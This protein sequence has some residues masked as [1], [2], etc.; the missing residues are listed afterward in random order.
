[1]TAPDSHARPPGVTDETVEALGKLS[2]A[3]EWLER[4]RGRLYDLHQMVGHLDFQMDEAARLFRAAGHDD[5]AAWVEEE[6]IGR[7]VLD[8]R[9]TFQIVEEFDDLYYEPIRAGERRL[10]DELADGRRHLFEAE[11][12]EQRRTHGRSGHER[13]PPAMHEPA[14]GAGSEDENAAAVM[15][16]GEPDPATIPSGGCLLSTARRG[17]VGPADAIR[18]GT[19]PGTDD[20]D[21]SDAERA[22]AS[23]VGDELQKQV[24]AGEQDPE[25]AEEK[26]IA[27]AERKGWDQEQTAREGSGS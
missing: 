12:K 16:P 19:M 4:A 20:R 2:E 9:W 13:R 17:R 1:M 26:A 8:G 5:A 22:P 27:E 25:R 11:L 23:R 24:D 14:L 10:L 18:G 21:P 6:V 7:N 15:D 3:I